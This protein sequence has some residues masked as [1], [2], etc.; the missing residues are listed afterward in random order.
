[1]GKCFDANAENGCRQVLQS[2]F[3]DEVKAR[4]LGSASPAENDITRTNVPIT[5]MR[6]RQVRRRVV[7]LQQGLGRPPRL[8]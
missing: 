5:R 2:G 1:L 3:D 6:F 4:W 7:G 8:G